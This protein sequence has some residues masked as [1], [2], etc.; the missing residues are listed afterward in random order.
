MAG[1][2]HEAGQEALVYSNVTESDTLSL[3]LLE[4][5]HFDETMTVEYELWTAILY[6]DISFKCVCDGRVAGMVKARMLD[7]QATIDILCVR[8]EFRRR[9][10]GRELLR[11][12]LESFRRL[13]DAKE[14]WLYV[15]PINHS[16]LGLYLSEGFAI[17]DLVHGVFR[18]GSPAF[19]LR[20][21]LV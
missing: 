7:G 21:Q 15:L 19:H 18:D 9:G 14:V 13:H 17:E 16:A 1:T 8:T 2:P 12:T 6:G 20:K 11:R 5:E 3:L 4:Q 10:I